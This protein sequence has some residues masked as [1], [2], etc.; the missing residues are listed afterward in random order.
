MHSFQLRIFGFRSNEDRDVRVGVFPEREKI[1]I[2]RIGFGCI[3]LHRIGPADLETRNPPFGQ[4]LGCV[5]RQV[6]GA[7]P[8][9]LAPG[10]AAL[11]WWHSR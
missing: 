3:A 8:T 4:I 5:F 11:A 6:N 7:V 9:Q 10:P 2:G 1:L